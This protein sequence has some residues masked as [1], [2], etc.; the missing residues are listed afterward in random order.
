MLQILPVHEGDV[1]ALRYAKS[2]ELQSCGLASDSP[3][4]SP[5]ELATHC[6]RETHG[7]AKTEA[8]IDKLLTNLIGAMGLEMLGVTLF[9]N[10]TITSP[11]DQQRDR[12]ICIQDPPKVPLHRQVGTKSKGGLALPV[13]HCARGF[14]SLES[15]YLHINRYIPGESTNCANF[16][17]YMLGGIVQWNEDRRSAAMSDKTLLCCYSYELQHVVKRT[18]TSIEADPGVNLQQTARYTV[19]TRQKQPG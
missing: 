1:A 9:D 19:R 17:A 11:W 18:A 6:T 15:F 3:Q 16:Q 10:E 8:L 14:T 2:L 7:A 12:I 13:Y 4:L 5:T